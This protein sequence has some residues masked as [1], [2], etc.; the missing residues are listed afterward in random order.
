MT[1]KLWSERLHQ[2]KYVIRLGWLFPCKDRLN[3]T[4]LA[5]NDH[6]D[7]LSIPLTDIPTTSTAV[8][9]SWEICCHWKSTAKG[10]GTR[11]PPLIPESDGGFP[12]LWRLALNLVIGINIYTIKYYVCDKLFATWYRKYI[13]SAECRFLNCLLKSLFKALN[14]WF[15]MV[16]FF[17]DYL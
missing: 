7:V 13:L 16:V 5:G 6:I 15:P 4:R 9:V 17:R 1:D 12:V 8:N 3:G 2:M 14:I 10:A 11:L